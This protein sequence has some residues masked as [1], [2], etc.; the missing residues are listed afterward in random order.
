MFVK[1]NNGSVEKYPYTIGQL[2]QDNPNTSFPRRL[3]DETLAEYG[4]YRVDSTARPEIDDKTQRCNQK[5][6]PELVDGKWVLG[7]DVYDKS[8]EEIDNQN[9]GQ[10]DLIRQR[11]NEALAKC[12]WVAVIDCPLSDEVKAEWL[13]YR[14]A[15]RDISDLP[16][17]PWVELP[18]DPDYVEVEHVEA[19]PEI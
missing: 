1:V 5:S 17:F 19:S 13:A 6:Q 3:T 18:N 10:A 4:L 16:D 2:R 11:R 8:Q 12:D 7:W 9:S 14:Q 15:L